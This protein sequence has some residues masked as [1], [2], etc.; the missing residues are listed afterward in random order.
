[1]HWYGGWMSGWGWLMMILVVVFWLLVIGG[2]VWLVVWLAGR[3]N[4]RSTSETPLEILKMRYARGEI[5]REEYER[6]RQEL[7]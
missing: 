1:M 3:T 2:V 6:M 4:L 7:S 5:T